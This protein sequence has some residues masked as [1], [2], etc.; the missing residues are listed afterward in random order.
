MHHQLFTVEST[1]NG[2]VANMS[3]L[4]DLMGFLRLP[5][6]SCSISGHAILQEALFSGSIRR[7]DYKM[8]GD[9]RLSDYGQ[10]RRKASRTVRI[11]GWARPRSPA[12]T[13]RWNSWTSDPM[14]LAGPNRL[15]HLLIRWFP[16]SMWFTLV[17]CF[18]SD[19]LV[20][21]IPEGSLRPQ[22]P[23]TTSI[24]KSPYSQMP[25]SACLRWSWDRFG[26]RPPRDN[27]FAQ[28]AGD[29]KRQSRDLCRAAGGL[30]PALQAACGA[31]SPW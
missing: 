31:M 8:I 15:V 21:E 18:R 2:L 14:L 3:S 6:D 16:H 28:G 12:R 19:L 5:R 30:L 26:W 25:F 29:S 23:S 17:T 1:A 10:T 4:P 27:L 11:A 13:A 7:I 22:R 24:S 20:D 9:L